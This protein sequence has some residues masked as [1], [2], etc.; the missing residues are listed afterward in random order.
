MTE[1][2]ID[3]RAW[4]GYY[5]PSLLARP[6][7]SGVEQRIENPRVGGSIPPPGTRTKVNI[8]KNSALETKSVPLFE[9]DP[10]SGT[11]LFHI[12]SGLFS[13]IWNGLMQVGEYVCILG[14]IGSVSK[15]CQASRS[16]HKLG[17]LSRPRTDTHS[18]SDF[19]QKQKLKKKLSGSAASE[20]KSSKA[21]LSA[22]SSWV[23]STQAYSKTS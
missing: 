8:N 14:N 7:S 5:P 1:N 9:P 23:P 4:L 17:G 20:E 11:L 16:R 19:C 6:G 13:R 2:A 18:T 10:K 12:G 15:G 22:P 3:K 21:P